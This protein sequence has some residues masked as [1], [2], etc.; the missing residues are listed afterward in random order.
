MIEKGWAGTPCAL[1]A[2]HW[3]ARCEEQFA[4]RG[5]V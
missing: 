1:T 2:E 5:G 3:P 4:S